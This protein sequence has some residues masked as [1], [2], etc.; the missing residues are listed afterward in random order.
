MSSKLVNM[1]LPEAVMLK[2]YLLCCIY[3]VYF[4]RKKLSHRK[5]A[6]WCSKSTITF[7][8]GAYSLTEKSLCVVKSVVCIV[9]DSRLGNEQI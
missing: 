8:D 3:L 1:S 2:Y 5:Q 9:L 7:Q 4:G 6:S